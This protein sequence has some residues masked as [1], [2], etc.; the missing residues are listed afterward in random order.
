MS[1]KYCFLKYDKWPLPFCLLSCWY[2]GTL[3]VFWHE[4][5][6][7]GIV[8]RRDTT[9]TFTTFVFFDMFTALRLIYTISVKSQAF[10][11][12]TT[13]T[14]KKKIKFFSSPMLSINRTVN[15]SHYFVDAITIATTIIYWLLWHHCLIDFSFYDYFIWKFN[16]YVSFGYYFI[17]ILTHI[18]LQSH[19]S[20]K[21]INKFICLAVISSM[22]SNMIFVYLVYLY[23]ASQRTLRMKYFVWLP[24]DA[25]YLII[26]L[27]FFYFYHNKINV[28]QFI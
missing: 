4:R 9:M 19:N 20:L 12:S 3:Y 11:I 28:N 6:S 16:L 2:S 13:I 1:C 25:K 8:S 23:S 17:A 15:I 10:A 26:F 27:K 7:D 21:W 5:T 24:F 18:F 22:W 14:I